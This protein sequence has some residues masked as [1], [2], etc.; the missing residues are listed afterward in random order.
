MIVLLNG[1]SLLKS[2][3]QF[4]LYKN[5]SISVIISQDNAR[6]NLLNNLYIYCLLFNIQI[7]ILW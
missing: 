6:P 2:V 7:K 1:V 4:L 5:A 3:Q